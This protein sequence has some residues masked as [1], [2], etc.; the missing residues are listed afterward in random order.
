[1]FSSYDSEGQV[2]LGYIHYL[3]NMKDNCELNMYNMKQ[4]YCLLVIV[5][6]RMPNFYHFKIKAN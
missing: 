2:Q 1:M 5:N 6:T 4:H 3:F